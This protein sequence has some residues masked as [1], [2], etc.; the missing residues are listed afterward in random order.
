M[1]A[2]TVEK[3]KFVAIGCPRWLYATGGVWNYLE[4]CAVWLDHLDAL[5]EP[6]RIEKNASCPPAWVRIIEAFSCKLAQPCPVGVHDQKM[7]PLADLPG[8]PLGAVQFSQDNLSTVRR[9]AR[10]TPSPRRIGARAPQA[11]PIH[12]NYPASMGT[13]T[14]G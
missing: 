10:T 13:V 1:D 9:K 7:A 11:G 4:A 5:T 8:A 6:M 3:R 2:E 12:V 14:V